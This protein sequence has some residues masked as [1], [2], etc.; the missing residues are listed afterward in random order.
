M[1]LHLNAKLQYVFP[2][3][4]IQFNSPPLASYVSLPARYCIKIWKHWTDEQHC[5][6]FSGVVCKNAPHISLSPSAWQHKLCFLFTLPWEICLV[7]SSSRSGFCRAL[8]TDW[9][10]ASAKWQIIELNPLL[11]C[12]SGWVLRGVGCGV[13]NKKKWSIIEARGPRRKH[14]LQR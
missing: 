8:H 7:L 11:H 10:I 14:L 3:V 13:N 5:S 12:R 1:H 6:H 4:P 2:G 9:C